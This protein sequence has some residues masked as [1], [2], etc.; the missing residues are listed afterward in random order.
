MTIQDLKKQ[1]DEFGYSYETIAILSGVELNKVEELFGDNKITTVT[2]E[3]RYAIEKALSDTF[4]Q[5]RE[6]NAAYI[7][8]KQGEFT[9]DD[10]Y[11]IP[12]DVRVEL[13]D[14]VI[15]YMGAPTTNHQHLVAE[16]QYMLMDYIKK[17]KGRCKVLSSPVD[18]QLN[19]DD[20]TM[21]QPDILVVCD[22]NKISK[23][24]ILGAP[25]L[26]VEV[27]SPS[28]R[29]KD[30]SVKLAKYMGAGVREY[31]IIDPDTKRVIV[32][33]WEQEEI[34]NIYG[35]GD[36]IPVGIFGGKCEVE[37]LNMTE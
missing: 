27:L 33:D 1:M 9:I 18:V 32:Y 19:C 26:V 25:D 16:I 8:K 3:E 24:G 21:V 23:E 35:F 28:T 2:Y 20:K 15:Y 31:W 37:F 29:K 7:T 6:S 17:N 12:E 30:M 11:A 14:G 10:Y 36:K 5:I 13:I 4:E 22:E 34:L